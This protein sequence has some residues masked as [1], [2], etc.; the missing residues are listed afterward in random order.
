MKLTEVLQEHRSIHKIE[1]E[2][3]T[4]AKG[5]W[6]DFTRY[7]YGYLPV[8]DGIDN[9]VEVSMRR[10]AES[11]SLE[12]VNKQGRLLKRFAKFFKQENGFPLTDSIMG[13]MGDRLQYHVSQETKTFYVDFTDSIDWE[14]GQF[15][16][17]DSC[18]WGCYNDSVPAFENAGGWGIRFYANENQEDSN[19]IG[20]TWIYPKN[21]V[22]LGFNSYG[23]ERP[24]VS[25]VIKS[26]Y[27]EHGIVLHY[28]AINLS[29][30]FNSD[31]P[32]INSGTGFVLYPEGVEPE[33]SYDLG[34]EYESEDSYR[35]YSCNRR[36]DSDD[37]FCANDEVWCEHCY[38]ERFSSCE[39]C[40]E[41]YENDDLH[42]MNGEYY[43]EHCISRLGGQQ[44][45]H[46]NQ[47]FTDGIVTEDSDE[48]YCESCAE[49]HCTYCET[50]EKWYDD[51]DHEQEESE[52]FVESPEYERDFIT[53]ELETVFIRG[54]EQNR[55]ERIYRHDNI[56]GLYVRQDSGNDLWN[57]VHEQSGLAVSYSI[58]TLLN[59][60]EFMTRLEGL[61]DWTL[62][63]QEISNNQDV[64]NQI[65]NIQREY[66]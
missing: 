44:C 59:A 1:L 33:E 41:T 13:I 34:I 51:H 19:G 9:K 39:R 43:C 35:C 30:S 60:L 62:P 46:C 56:P 24:K 31:I 26:I 47:Y 16:H 3:S 57:V 54:D 55:T 29:N 53:C 27:K 42:R 17:S 4:D 10:F 36:V 18:W 58:P 12:L 61:I 21:G 20:R 32:Y 28:K 38:N 23:V 48:F 25:K 40:G 6:E 11:D 22:L 2:K 45:E 50:C 64:V 52:S 14:D 66:K 8:D 37:V 15:G 5:F 49:N 7:M 65:I 63:S